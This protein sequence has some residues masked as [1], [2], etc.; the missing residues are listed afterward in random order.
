MERIAILGAGDLGESLH[1]YMRDRGDV[2]VAGFLDDAR[3]RGSDFLGSGV[4]GAASDAV[5]LYKAGAFDRLAFA[6]G[7]RNFTVRMDLF[8]RLRAAGIPFYGV[9]HPSAFVHSTAR[10]G[11]GVHVFPGTLVDMAVELRDNIV[12]NTGCIVAHHSSVH[13]HCYFGP[14]VR[15]AGITEIGERCF[16]GIGASI[17]EKIRIGAG[18]VIAA[19]A[20]VTDS[21]EPGS[22]MAG[23]PATCKKRIA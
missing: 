14:G 21:V 19:G 10:I 18:S 20:V 2:A 16:V 22:L 8:E 4:L 9:V 15:V 6:I 17:V 5:Q 12:L 1:Q 3:P 11:E 7:Y 23:V 13:S